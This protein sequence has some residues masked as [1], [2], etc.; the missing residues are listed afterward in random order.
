M[1]G[2][3]RTESSTAEERAARARTRRTM[4]LRAIAAMADLILAVHWSVRVSPFSPLTVSLAGAFSAAI[5]L[6]LRWEAT[7]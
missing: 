6:G 7:P 4:L 3:Q 1:R 5:G 2:K